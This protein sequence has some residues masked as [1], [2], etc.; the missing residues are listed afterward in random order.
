MGRRANSSGRALRSVARQRRPM[1]RG[2]DRAVPVFQPDCI[3]ARWICLGNPPFQLCKPD[4]RT[5]CECHPAHAR[6]GM[7]GRVTTARDSYTRHQR[8]E[9]NNQI[10][11][12]GGYGTSIAVCSGLFF[13]SE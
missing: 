11:G 7:L 2:I 6:L 13:C 12:E 3:S 9:P 10:P 8:H 5:A 4:T 1:T